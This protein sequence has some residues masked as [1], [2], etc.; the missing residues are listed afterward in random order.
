VPLAELLPRVRRVFDLDADSGTIDGH[1]AADPLLAPVVA[2]HGGLRVPGAWDSFETTIRAVLGQQVSVDR[3]TALAHKLLERYGDTCLTAPAVLA[4]ATP[5]EIGMPGL[6][7]RAISE[8]ARM[9]ASGRIELGETADSAPL[10]AAL[11]ALPGIGPW[12]AGYVAMRVAK[13]PDAL[14]VKDW[15]V[16]K[17]L[18]AAAEVPGRRAADRERA[19][20][21]RPWRAYAVM[22]L[23]KRS[24]L[25]KR[26]LTSQPRSPVVTRGSLEDGCLEER[27]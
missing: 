6:R 27:A 9:V 22:Y 25:S 23:W 3:A 4:C 19:E 13:D 21:W 2:S 1:L 10:Q 18:A 8:L 11:R 26:P 20:R 16:L 14:P 17:M 12:T 15:V 24:A 7:G 5:A